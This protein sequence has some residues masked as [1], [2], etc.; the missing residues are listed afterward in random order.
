MSN[1]DLD[2]SD[3][4]A[5]KQ[6]KPNN[7]ELDWSSE[8]P[9]EQMQQAH[10]YIYGA[11]KYTAEHP[12]LNSI[13]NALAKPARL[14]NKGTEELGL[15]QFAQS[16]LGA[17]FSLVRSGFNLNPNYKLPPTIFEQQIET[18]TNPVIANAMRRTGQ[19][20][21]LSPFKGAV[22]EPFK[23]VGG[24]WKD[25]SNEEKLRKLQELLEQRDTS[26]RMNKAKAKSD[27]GYSTPELMQMQIPKK[28]DQLRQLQSQF[29]EMS[30][31]G[32]THPLIPASEA[33][34]LANSSFED[35]QN[36][37]REGSNYKRDIYDAYMRYLRGPQDAQTGRREGGFM[38]HIGSE[39]D[40]LQRDLERQRVKINTTPSEQQ[41][42]KELGTSRI[43]GQKIW[44]MIPDKSKAS[45][46]KQFMSDSHEEISAAE[47]MRHYRELKSQAFKARDNAF[48]QGIS[49]EEHDRWLK[50]SQ[51]LTSAS[52]KFG[53]ILNNQLG[54]QH[55][56]RL[57][58]IDARYSQ[59]IAPLHDNPIYTHMLNKHTA[60]G[61]VGELLSTAH[62]ANRILG[63]F[64]GID[65]NLQ[66]S[67]FGQQFSKNMKQLLRP[68]E[69]AEA[70]SIA[71]PEL[72]RLIQSYRTHNTQLQQRVESD[73]LNKQI[74][75]LQDQL[76][77][78]ETQYNR[79]VQDT[80]EKRAIK[81]KIDM[82][83]NKIKRR[84]SRID[85]IK[86]TGLKYLGLKKVYDYF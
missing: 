79:I 62:P 25:M 10:P 16:Y 27:F 52:Q 36:Y 19:I 57:G 5:Q 18:D 42:L 44:E 80:A 8:N 58:N 14:V 15:P 40:A 34:R 72:G 59:F 81:N 9:L 76:K 54:P 30:G 69:Q 12:V 75:Q 73:S 31:Q 85:K 35:I 7:I 66:R 3:A 6:S 20:L 74:T 13:V 37:A 24:L 50:R 23:V 17:P 41:K 32:A 21:G 22:T 53:D 1:I 77:N 45:L 4:P 47:A 83:N 49:P 55:L 67:L 82:I 61:N 38:Q 26:L 71:N 46:L 48:S 28:A 43:G 60:P 11:A 33:Q 64:A 68:N 63:L 39:Y 51:E 70:Y 84:S 65:P 2:W 56:E 29:Q 86:N 78:A